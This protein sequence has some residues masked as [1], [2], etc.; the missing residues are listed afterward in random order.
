MLRRSSMDR[1]TQKEIAVP[2]DMLA[3][4]LMEQAGRPSSMTRES[5]RFAAKVCGVMAVTTALTFAT[6]TTAY[7]YFFAHPLFA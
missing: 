1:T 2:T 4:L 7:Q 5:R 6:L 3:S